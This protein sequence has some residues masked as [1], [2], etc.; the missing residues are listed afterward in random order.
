MKGRHNGL[1][2]KII[3]LNPRAFYVPCAA[4]NLNLVLNDAAKASLEIT[5]F[6]AMVQELYVFFSAST[7][8]WQVLKDQIPT[9]TLKPLSSTRW[10]SRIDALKV[11]RYNLEKHMTLYLHFILIIAETLKPET[12]QIHYS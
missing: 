12:W 10:E 6:F 8:R 4:H 1:Q 7:K 11:L 3:E 9:L 5:S 2:K